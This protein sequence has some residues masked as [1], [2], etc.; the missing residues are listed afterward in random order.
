M[1]GRLE[2]VVRND[3]AKESSLMFAVSVLIFSGG[4]IEVRKESWRGVRYVV[5]WK[6]GGNS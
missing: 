1:E 3:S 4:G 2:R 5:G 6:L